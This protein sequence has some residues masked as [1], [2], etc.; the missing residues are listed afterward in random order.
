M[1]LT[2]ALLIATCLQV[3][4]K[5]FS[6]TR[7]TLSLQS[8]ELR[9]ALFII[10]KKSSY[11]FLYNDDVVTPGIK[12]NVEAVNTP[13]TEVLDKLL[14]THSLFYKILDNNL[15]VISA[16]DNAV[17]ETKVNGK[18]VASS[19]ET[20]AGVSIRVKGSSLGTQTDLNGVFSLTVPDNAVLV[21]SYVGYDTQEVPVSGQSNLSITLQPSTKSLE[22]VVVVG[23][24]TQRKLDVTGSVAQVRGEDI[25]KQ[26]DVNPISALQGKV[27]GVLITNSGIPGASPQITIRGTGTVYGSTNPLY[28]VDGVW[29][30][31]INFLSPSDIESLSI[32]KDASSESIYGVRAANGV[33]LITTRKGK[34]GQSVINY[35]GYV[36]Y[37]HVTNLLKMADGTEYATLLNEKSILNGTDTVFPN[38]ASF[39]KGTDWYRQVLRDAFTTSHQLSLSGGGE[40]STYNFSVGYLDQQGIAK[41]N[42]F[43]R[44]NTRLQNDYQLSN[45]VKVGF[46]AIG[47]YSKS[48]DI[49]S[50]LMNQLFNAA[51]IVPVKY[52]NGSYG[53]PADYSLG[54]SVSNPQV[55][56]DFYNQKANIYRATGSGYI[57][58]KFAKHFTLHSSLGGEYAHSE[59]KAFV[60]TYY[61]TSIQNNTVSLLTVYRTETKNWILENTLNYENSFGD[62]HITV[63]AGQT[64][65]QYRSYGLTGSIKGVPNSDDAGLFFSL[66]T[67][68]TGN[69]TDFGDLSTTASYFGRVNYSFKNRYLLTLSLRGDG[70]SKFSGDQRWGY[71]PSV[72]AGWVISD[73]S[74]MANQKI[75]NTLKLRGSWGKIG[76]A[77]VPSNTAVQLVDQ[78]GGRIAFFGQ[79]SVP[80]PGAGINTL[81]PPVLYWEKGV[82]TD[83]GLEAAVLHNHLTIEADFYNKKTQQAIFDAPVLASLGLT[84]S[85]IIANQ[86]D[87]QNQGFE[88][89][90]T[91]RNT[92][93]KNWSYSVS[94]NISINDNKVLSAVTGSNP[95]YGGG[96]GATS[97]QYTTRTVAGQPISE[98]YGE[99]VIGIF[100]T[101]ADVTS[102]T[103]KTGQVIQP[104]ALPGDFKYAD[105]NGDGVIDGKDRVVLG[106]PNP[107]YLY[108]INTNWS[109]KAFDLTL[110]FQ[111]VAKVDIYNAQQ[112]LRYGNENYTRYFF[113]HRW[114][115]PGTSN[116][117]PSA[118]IVGR[119]NYL[120]NSWFV[121]NGS[122]FRVRNMQLGYT[123]PSAL[124]NRWGLKK[125]RVY[126]NAQNAFTFTRYRGFN[127]EVVTAPRTVPTST[128][129]GVSSTNPINMGIDT[130]VYPVAATFN[131]GINLTL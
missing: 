36:G 13:L 106:N 77:S 56:V 27:A 51:P 37:Q 24:G 85:S 20:L 98:F 119:S 68:N 81:V 82:G 83:I 25:A 118:D 124:T 54:N 69:I 3:S 128:T 48:N 17:L 8:V 115:G 93:S 61:G 108:G 75:F 99:Q 90:L 12:V 10:E 97:G 26:P 16:S 63:L 18:I 71:F 125:L 88:L 47:S 38:P 30:D 39:G 105:T 64:A 126:A 35:N 103:S 110:D 112:G 62:H 32:L 7:I 29:Y 96:G 52:A 73:E 74:F 33:V 43:Q 104:N 58:I 107:K 5:S 31:D 95:I 79:P 121:Q 101:K 23:Y 55:T 6:Q 11:R 22:Q 116:D 66:G 113:D 84:N 102:Y 122:Y 4:A 114:H 72:G 123:L 28:V 87:F 92:I 9:K 131:F 40:K 34:R 111:G 41:T 65:Q 21:V 49:Y 91:W 80:Y 120:P 100:Q 94:G 57:D 42:D 89:A 59:V 130:Q 19:G 1:K 76:N 129:V 46:T 14:L 78:A 44:Y 67:P 53:D 45:F 60:P 109:Y 15:V 127:P 117:N 2:I 50:G 70:S 86:A